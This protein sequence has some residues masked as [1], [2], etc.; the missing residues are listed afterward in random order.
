MVELEVI[1]SV[2]VVWREDQSPTLSQS[3]L[4]SCRIDSDGED[5]DFQGALVQLPPTPAMADA[6]DVI[7]PD[8]ATQPEDTGS[9]D[10]E[11][12]ALGAEPSADWSLHSP[13]INDDEDTE[14]P[15]M[16]GGRWP[17]KTRAPQQRLS[18]A[19]KGLSDAPRSL[20]EPRGRPDW[21][22]FDEAISQ[23]MCAVTSQQVYDTVTQNE[24]K[25]QDTTGLVV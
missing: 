9:D 22:L 1:D 10:E 16:G 19:A 17:T 7:Y 13:T 6:V 5:D 4:T 25:R 11:E 2:H 14:Q 23:E 15:G 3:T 18:Y 24:V 20:R 8:P 12:S 21:P